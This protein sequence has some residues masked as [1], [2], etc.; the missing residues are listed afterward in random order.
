MPTIYLRRD[1][2]DEIVRRGYDV[3]EYVNK[4]VENAL[5]TEQPKP[6]EEARK[7]R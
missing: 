4:V 1:L 2:Y 7:K 3:T 6:E 5:K